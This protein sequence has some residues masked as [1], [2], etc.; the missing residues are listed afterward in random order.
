MDKKTR[1]QVVEGI[2]RLEGLSGVGKIFRKHIPQDW[3]EAIIEVT[4]AY[5]DDDFVDMGIHVSDLA[6][7]LFDGYIAPPPPREKV[8]I[9]E[10]GSKQCKTIEVS[11]DTAMDITNSL[12]ECLNRRNLIV[13]N[14]FLV[15][16][17]DHMPDNAH[18]LVYDSYE[19]YQREQE[20]LKELDE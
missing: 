6:L 9:S 15:Y 13:R 20:F 10:Q 12:I 2:N 3:R 1:K 18:R 5:F 8:P 16:G 4:T 11:S 19:E 7:S 17:P 14:F